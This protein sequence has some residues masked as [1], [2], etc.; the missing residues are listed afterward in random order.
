MEKPSQ[1]MVFSYISGALFAIAW[2]IFIDATVYEK[3]IGDTAGELNGYYYIPGIA[4]T[5][6]LVMIN[7]ISWNDLNDTGFLS[8]ESVSSKARVW[9]LFSF[10]V[11]FAGICAAIWLGIAHWF[12]QN[13]MS[14]WGGAALIIQNILIFISAMFFRFSKPENDS[15]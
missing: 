8:G 13:V 12:Q 6:A 3:H 7:A 1:E 15:I 14:D 9:M 4:S 10:I 2:W 11:A 5:I